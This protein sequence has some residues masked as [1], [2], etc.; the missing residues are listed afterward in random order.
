MMRDRV[1]GAVCLLFFGSLLLGC[2]DGQGHLSV[3]LDAE[4]TIRRGLDPG[5]RAENVRDG[6]QVRHHKYLL[7]V[8]DIDL[9]LAKDPHVEAAAHEVFVVD[10]A[11]VP[12][13]GE[14]LW[15]LEDLR[16]SRW[17]FHY[18]TPGADEDA[19]RHASVEQSDFDRMVEEGWT[20]V[21]E[22]TL[23]KQ[24]GR[25][26][27][28]ASL[29]APPDGA[30][31]S[32]SNAAGDDCYENPEIDFVIEADVETAYG[33]CEMDHVPG[34]SVPD[35]GAQ[36]VAISIHGDHIFFNGFAEGHEGGVMRLAQWLADSDLDLDGR[37]TRE[38]LERISI[39]ELPEID[40]RYQL[41][42]APPGIDLVTMWDYVRAQL[43][44]QGHFNGEGECDIDG[45][46]H[47]HDH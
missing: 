38:E 8:G 24:D 28:P 3:L 10:L 25:S 31:P 42:G 17:N 14:V 30:A 4:D 11:K 18:A 21:I 23:S 1:H 2:G 26:C 41:G 33:P 39:S 40:A 27:P 13:Q 43:K 44:T 7:A 46:R 45:E 35:G 15:Q 47:D 34:V 6:W 12:S 16:A 9:Q 32:G 29:A 19:I 22:G 36:T 20:Y 37:V 5:D